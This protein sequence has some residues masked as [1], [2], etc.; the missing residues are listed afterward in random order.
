MYKSPCIVSSHQRCYSILGSESARNIAPSV[1]KHYLPTVLT[2]ELCSSICTTHQT[3]ALQLVQL[4][5]G[6]VAC[7][8]TI[9][10]KDLYTKG[11]WSLKRALSMTKSPLC[12]NYHSLFGLHFSTRRGR[13]SQ[14]TRGQDSHTTAPRQC[15]A[16]TSGGR[17]RRQP[18]FVLINFGLQVRSFYT[19]EVDS[20][21]T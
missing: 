6:A 18:G 4:W 21:H 13:T 17:K 15:S 9:F 1:H 10:L 5:D 12:I 8:V 14:Y 16:V 20:N 2:F 19:F 7:V 3:I 11:S